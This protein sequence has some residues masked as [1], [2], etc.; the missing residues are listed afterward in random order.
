MRAVPCEDGAGGCPECSTMFWPIHRDIP[1][2]SVCGSANGL[3]VTKYGYVCV[4][5]HAFEDR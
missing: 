3:K 1:R 4:F 2:C 5:E